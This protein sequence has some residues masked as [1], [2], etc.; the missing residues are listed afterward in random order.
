MPDIRV[1]PAVAAAAA[2]AVAAAAALMYLLGFFAGITP[3]GP[4]D[5]QCLVN[6]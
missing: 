5:E 6:H 1:K 2:A 3:P 4:D